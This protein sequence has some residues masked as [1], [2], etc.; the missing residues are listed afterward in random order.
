MTRKTRG[1]GTGGIET[2]ASSGAPNREGGWCRAVHLLGENS[3]S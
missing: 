2:A 3:Q 1:A